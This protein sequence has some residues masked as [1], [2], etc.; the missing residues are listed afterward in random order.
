MASAPCGKFSGGEKSR[1]ALAL[2]I[3][4]KPNLLLLDEP[5]NHLDLEMRE[6]LTLALQEYEGGVVLVSHDRHL[7]RTTADQ[8]LLVADGKVVPFDGDLDEYGAWLNTQR[9]Q[10]MKCETTDSNRA[11]RR[12]QRE[13]AAADRQALLARR[14]PLLKEI[15]QLE[16]KLTPWQKEKHEIDTQLADPATYTAAEKAT[17]DRLLKRQG[18]LAQHIETAEERWLECQ[19]ELEAIDAPEG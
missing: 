4:K 15:E 12:Q 5:T 14:R 8:L 17:L 2:L 13:Q 11:E 9:E 10:A 19:T 3:W 1:L 7:L 16:K 18:E 6:A